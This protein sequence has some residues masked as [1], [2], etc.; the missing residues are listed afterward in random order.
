MKP[1]QKFSELNGRRKIPG[2]RNG[3]TLLELTVVILV[4][5]SLISVLFVG[6][7]A[8]KRG[9][10]RTLCIMN[11]RNVQNAVRS[12][13]NL[14]GYKPEDNVTGL[15]VRVIGPGKFIEPAPTCPSAGTYSYG[16]DFGNDTIP[17]I[18]ELYMQCS[19][20]ATAEHVPQNADYW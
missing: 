20:S 6:A 18:G 15:Q 16:P 5:L 8:W 11:I 1:P 9:S 3:M 10:D 2:K 4:L 12:F 17:P 7:N 13:S 14:Y 19:L